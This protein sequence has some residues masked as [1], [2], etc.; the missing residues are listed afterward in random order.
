ML[1]NV[2]KYGQRMKSGKQI[3]ADALKSDTLNCC[4]LDAQLC[5]T[6]WPDEL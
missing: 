5:L 3:I 2:T 4:C 1:L 6:L